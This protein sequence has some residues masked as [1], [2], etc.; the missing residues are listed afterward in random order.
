MN[1]YLD[2]VMNFVYYTV[3]ALLTTLRWIT[4]PLRPVWY[5]LY[6]F[7]LPFIYIAHFLASAVAYPARKLPGSAIEVCIAFNLLLPVPLRDHV[8]NI[9]LPLRSIPS[10]P[11]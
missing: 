11:C 9:K 8:Y 2:V 1:P 5:L 6:V 4:Y 10:Q 3:Y 7:A